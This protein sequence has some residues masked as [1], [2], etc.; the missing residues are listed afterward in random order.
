MK[1]VRI[2]SDSEAMAEEMARCWCEQA[3]QAASD[4]RVFSVTLSG[5]NTDPALYG[6]L[7]EP[8]WR[9]R[10]PWESVHIFFADERC[11]PP[12]HE[13]SNYKI[14]CNYLLNHISIPEANIH[15]MRGEED[16]VEESLRYTEDIQNHLVLRKEGT[17]FFDWVF[18]GVGPDGH[19]ASLFPGHDLINSTNLCE[20]AQ[21][22][23]TGQNRVT[24][25]PAAINRSSRITYH[26]IGESKAE[27]VSALASDPSASNIYPA[28]QIQG[29]WFLDRESASKLDVS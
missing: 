13:E 16:P 2:F 1:S 28:A 29:E 17:C 10:T 15:R 12:D 9:D 6:K 7:A 21:H 14:I 3:R 4:H 26:A 18:L 27:I 11:V 19:T 25:T 8:K 23:E 20:V 24:M 5:G 22:P